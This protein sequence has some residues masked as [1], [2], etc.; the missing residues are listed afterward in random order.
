MNKIKAFLLKAADMFGFKKSSKYVSRYLHKANMRSGIFMSAIIFILECWL[1]IRQLDK[2][3]IPDLKK[4]YPFFST[5]FSNTSYFWVLMFFGVSSF[6]ASLIS[7]SILLS[8][9]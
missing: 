6:S 3:I 2:Y 5:V 9:K 8:S 1:I 7:W 4:G